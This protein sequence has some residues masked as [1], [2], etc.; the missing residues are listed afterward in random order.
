MK[1]FLFRFYPFCKKFVFSS[2]RDSKLNQW[3]FIIQVCH[4]KTTPMTFPCSIRNESYG[5][6]DGP[7][8]NTAKKKI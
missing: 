5:L 8:L 7:M 4:K 6:T 3:K 2:W 1:L